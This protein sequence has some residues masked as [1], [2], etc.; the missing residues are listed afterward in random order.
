[1]ITLFIL[2][3]IFAVI[4]LF[5]LAVIAAVILGIELYDIDRSTK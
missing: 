5:I 3:I 1:M 4:T 2:A